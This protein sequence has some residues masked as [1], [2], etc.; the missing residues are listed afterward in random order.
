MVQ[1]HRDLHGSIVG[2]PTGLASGGRIVIDSLVVN[3][4]DVSGRAFNRTKEIFYKIF[5]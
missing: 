4:K 2:L 5:L 3:T 1:H